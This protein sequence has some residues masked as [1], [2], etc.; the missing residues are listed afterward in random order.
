MKS[1]A[2]HEAFSKA[3]TDK[4]MPN[5]TTTHLLVNEVLGHRDC[6]R[7]ETY[8]VLNRA[9]RSKAPQRRRNT[10]EKASIILENIVAATWINVPKHK[11]A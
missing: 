11:Q 8:L 7:Q 10:R 3:C 1:S 9:G 4:K 6:F 5:T 2:V